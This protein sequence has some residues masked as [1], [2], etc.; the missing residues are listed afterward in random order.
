M[1]F[2]EACRTIES[3]FA[4]ALGSPQRVAAACA[5][6]RGS[7]N[8]GLEHESL[9]PLTRLLGRRSGEILRP[10]FDLLEEATEAA[11]DPLP[12]LAGMLDVRDAG[13]CRRALD[14]LLELAEGGRLGIEGDFAVVLAEKVEAEGSWFA[15][16]EALTKIGRIL[17]RAT[18]GGSRPG[19][20]PRVDL[21]LHGA[22]RPVRRLAARL[23][24][25]EGAPPP[26]R[27]EA[28]IGIE[29]YRFL[30]PYLAYAQATH[31]DLLELA[32][33]S[34]VSER[35]LSDLT[36]AEVALGERILREVIVAAGWSR[37][38]LGLEVRER[39]GLS[40]DGSFPLTVG[41]AEA[42]LIET[43]TGVRRVWRRI[44]AFAHGG[45]LHGEARG[46]SSGDPVRRFRAY[47]LA[48][49]EALGEILDLGP[50]STER[51]MRIVATMDR[52]VEE[53][54]ALFSGFDDEAG[55]LPCAYASLRGAVLAELAG[56]SG[57]S[58]SAHLTRLVQMF[59]DPRSLAEVRTLHGLKRYLHQKGLRLGFRLVETVRAT[60]RT[61]DLL[62]VGSEKVQTIVRKIQY[63]EFEPEESEDLPGMRIPYAVAIVAEGMGRHLLHDFATFPDVKIFC[64]G[65]EVH[66]YASYGTHPAFLRIDFAP[67]ARGGMVDLEYYGVSKH[68]LDHHPAPNL[69]AVRLF[70][71]GMD[72]DC[73]VART[74]VHAR[75]DKERAR[76]LGDL[77]AKAE[78]LF[79]LLP[80]LMDVDW[81]IGSLRLDEDA[82]AKVAGAWSDFF[83]RWGSLPIEK[84]LTSDRL[85]ILTGIAPDPAG[86]REVAW[87]GRGPYRDRFSSEAPPRF[88]AEIREA[89]E[90]RGLAEVVPFLNAAPEAFGQLGLE[91]DLLRPLR[92]AVARGEILEGPL[93]FVP[94]AD[95]FRREHEAKIFASILEG[96]DAGIVRAA[97]LARLVG[98]IERS[99]RFRM[100]GSVNGY[101]VDRAGLELRGEDA[102]LHVLRD[103]GG[104]ARLAIFAREGR[105]FSSRPTRRAAW[106]S[107]GVTDAAR[108]LPLLR[109]A[110][111]LTAG[112]PSAAPE[113]AAVLRDHFSVP[114]PLGGV[115][116]VPGERV[117]PGVRAAPGKAAGPAVLGT[118]GRVPGDVDEAIL[119]AATVRPDDNNFI[120]RSAGIVSTG[121][122]ILSHAGLL[123]LQFHK[124]A[125]LIDARWD[126]TGRFLVYRA[127]EYEEVR[128]H[129]GALS[130]AARKNVR[131]REERILDGDILDLDV[132]RGLL[133]NLGHEPDALAL[134]E[135]LRQMMQAARSVEQAADDARL[136]ALRGQRLRARHQLERLFGRLRDPNLARH[137]VRELFI[138]AAVAGGAHGEIADLVALLLRNRSVAGA[139][140]DCVATLLR[141]M[142]ERNRTCAVE[143]RDGIPTAGGLHEALSLRLEAMRARER[144]REARRLVSGS[145]LAEA[146]TGAWEDPFAEDEIEERTRARLVALRER[147]T[148]EVVSA[149]AYARRHLLRRIDTLD[150]VLDTPEADRG[151]VLAQARDLEA[152]DRR[153]ETDLRD[154]YILSPEESGLELSSLIGMKAAN[155]SEIGRILGSE[156]VPDWHVVTDAA[157]RGILDLPIESDG[158]ALLLRDAIG[159]IL[160]RDGANESQ[161]SFLIGKLWEGVRI[162]QPIEAAIAEAYRRLA[163]QQPGGAEENGEGPM[164]AVRSSGLEEDTEGAARAGEFETFLFVRGERDLLEA[165]RR[166]WS[167]LWSPRAIRGRATLGIDPAGSGGGVLVQRICWSRVSGVLTTIN[168]GDGRM[169]EIVVNAALGLGEGLVSGEVGADLIVVAKEEDP[170]EG[171]LR[172]RYLTNDKR[173][174]IVFD[175]KRGRGTIRVETLYHER[176]R[177]ALE[178]VE[179]CELV[180]AATRL[181]AVY[182]YPLDI[183]F[184]IEG[185]RLRILQARPLA[186][187]AAILRETIDR[188][189][190]IAHHAGRGERKENR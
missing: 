103:R 121:G 12:I 143:A 47:N 182:G 172:F 63:V 119:V 189:P 149:T 39:I 94:A 61:V 5:I 102:A 127:A 40:M 169:R 123:A 168:V 146:Q 98:G 155:L 4:V 81:V 27:T 136:L 93:G 174:K 125:L 107:N 96:D 151:P 15:G 176:F 79:R 129:V 59:E 1:T 144:L 86:E 171:S 114:N 73:E 139:A 97:G 74:R 85:G 173:E 108:V 20:E 148:R 24:D 56:V 165:V 35:L 122:G 179:L 113:E 90:A 167:G 62:L 183:E 160:E 88:V 33:D 134:H 80:L 3:E 29:A 9:I 157:L 115:P 38:N 37:L 124:P 69:D 26:K 166:V 78:G 16:A 138:G 44:L 23:L 71:R 140:R 132:E 152:A 104:L 110:N 106:R 10:L 161:K 7:L 135:G 116:P 36:S 2:D 52:I 57:G 64:Y 175:R 51:V 13:L 67:P 19:V 34:G 92:D 46:D 130:V 77:C 83:L 84:L 128:S 30:A 131:E 54:A 105:L 141:E 89:L 153:R 42:A 66:Y 25:L 31:L 190:L 112:V 11:S 99:L 188:H 117:L 28:V 58:L 50:L 184:G 6:L 181:E 147:M 32:G 164:V 162:P 142:E 91:R 111:Y 158:G 21:Y 82:R 49:A 186:R 170:G 65:N 8:S 150:S 185:D 60:N 68:D 109:R 101:Q 154:R 163:T 145:G 72:Y 48:H 159:S 70:F 180:R 14:R 87:S 120:Y 137:A 156:F 55:A 43:C 118:R 133:R 45:D 75:Y 178:Y 187:S 41:P 18:V 76:D 17:R 126:E 100:T 177:P 22:S 95:R 53:F